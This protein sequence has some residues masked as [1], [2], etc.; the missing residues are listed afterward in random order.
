MYI[1]IYIF[2]KSTRIHIHMYMYT[3]WSCLYVYQ[4]NNIRTEAT[5]KLNAH[6]VEASYKNI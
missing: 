6:V 5:T 1:Y 2:T 3:A 4:M